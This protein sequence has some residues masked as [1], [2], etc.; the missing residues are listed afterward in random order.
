[1][2][3]K[4]GWMLL[5]ILLV[6]FG[7]CW[8][9]FRKMTSGGGVME[10][11]IAAPIDRVFATLADPDSMLVWMHPGTRIWP[12]GGGQLVTGDT[13]RIVPPGD[14]TTV[15]GTRM[16][17][18]IVEAVPPTRLVMALETDS[19][20]HGNA[21]VAVI[22]DSLVVIGTDS[23]KR[24]TMFHSPMIDSAT[25]VA[26]DSSRFAGALLGAGQKMMIAGMRMVAEGEGRRLKA[27]LEGREMPR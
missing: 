20:G 13:L 6:I 10:H 15:S 21:T 5:A 1:M 14:T 19:A 17:W 12:L 4:F 11:T 22:T 25:A 3:R 24:I 23:T 18:R 2:V 7:A 27:R 8:F 9:G 16:L 26:A